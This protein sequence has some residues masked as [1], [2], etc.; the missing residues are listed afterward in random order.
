MSEGTNTG[1][2]FYCK[3]TKNMAK[4]RPY[5]PNGEDVCEDCVKADPEKNRIA[6]E[7]YGKLLNQAAK[8]S[9]IV[10]LSERGPVPVVAGSEV[11]R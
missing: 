6:R 7:Q 8:V 11:K 2:C 4:I 10:F 9:K 3:Q 1:T 5:G